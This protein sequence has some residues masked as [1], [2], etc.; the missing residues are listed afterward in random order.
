MEFQFTLQD[1]MLFLAGVLGIAVGILLISTLW[2]IKKLV[3]TLR[4]LL[5]TNQES[6]KKTVSTMPEIFDNV[7]QISIN[8][9][10]TTDKLKI[11]VPVILQE[12]ESVTNAAKESIELTGV[13]IGNMG[14]GINET[15]VAHKKETFGFMPYL[16]IFDEVLQIIYRTFSSRK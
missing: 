1:L 12:V 11:S 6:I 13:V 10:D 2:N 5:E 4:T 3:G 15:I 9:R 8:V 7:G 16:H 14:S